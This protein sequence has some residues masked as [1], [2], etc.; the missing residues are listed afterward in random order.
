M[1]IGNRESARAAH[2]AGITLLQGFLFGK[3]SLAAE[4]AVDA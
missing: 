4:W 2:E 3:P 1:R